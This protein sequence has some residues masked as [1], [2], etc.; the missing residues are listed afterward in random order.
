[1][2]SNTCKYG[3]RAVL[4][5][6]V[7]GKDDKKIGIKK[8]AEDLDLPGPFLGKIMQTLAKQKLLNSVKGPH[9]GFSLAKD[10]NS[11]SLYD[12]VSII[13]GTDVFHECLIGIKI[14]ENNPEHE[15]F[16][17]FME[18]SHEVRDKLKKVFKDQSI[19]EFASGIKNIEQILR[20]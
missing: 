8:I 4:Y 5:I 20:I 6:A 3:I 14:C 10:A 11:I 15:E 7:N 19:G 17:P 2:I 1:M 16:C 18:K 12:I 13:D 9:G